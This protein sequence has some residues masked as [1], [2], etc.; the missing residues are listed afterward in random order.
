[1]TPSRFGTE[2]YPTGPF[3]VNIGV[4]CK[5][6][7]FC[8]TSTFLKLKLG[9]VSTT[10][11]TDMIFFMILSGI[12][13]LSLLSKLFLK[14]GC[15][16]GGKG[17]TFCI[18]TGICINDCWFLSWWDILNDGDCPVPIF[19]S[20]KNWSEHLRNFKCSLIFYF[21][22]DA[23]VVVFGADGKLKNAGGMYLRSWLL[24][25]PLEV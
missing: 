2:P 7:A 13:P 4:H 6:A 15:W 1:M 19:Y 22:S 8:M 25:L 12:T 14:I 5:L 16:C 18:G 10:S 17:G 9:F 3:G 20:L 11:L 23:D 21:L 24:L